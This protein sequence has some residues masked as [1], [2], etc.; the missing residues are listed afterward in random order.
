MK[1]GVFVIGRSL[2]RFAAAVLCLALAVSLCG[3][4]GKT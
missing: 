1:F 2:K 4:G 3:C